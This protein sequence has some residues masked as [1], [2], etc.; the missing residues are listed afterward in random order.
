MTWL[1]YYGEDYVP[2][3]QQ[4]KVFPVSCVMSS[5]GKL[6]KYTAVGTEWRRI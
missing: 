4:D 1:R 2:R 5:Y 3:K 6:N